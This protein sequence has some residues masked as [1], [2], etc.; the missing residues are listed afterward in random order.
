MSATDLSTKDGRIAVLSAALKGYENF[1][2]QNVVFQAK[3]LSF[4]LHS[5]NIRC[6]MIENLVCCFFS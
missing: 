5:E 6:P 1:P 3:S 4:T 2:Q